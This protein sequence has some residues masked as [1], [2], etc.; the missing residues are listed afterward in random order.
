MEDKQSSRGL[1][2]M[3]LIGAILLITLIIAFILTMAANYDRVNKEMVVNT[4]LGLSIGVLLGLLLVPI[5][6]PT[7]G[8]V[9]GLSTMIIIVL[10]TAMLLILFAEIGI[11]QIFNLKLIPDY[12][13]LFGLA[14]ASAFVLAMAH[15][16]QWSK[17]EMAT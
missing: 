17:K 13:L 5:I 6:G 14:I 11:T 7:L 15:T 3:K 16:L 9:N 2:A 4:I 12:P 8:L 10:I 1:R